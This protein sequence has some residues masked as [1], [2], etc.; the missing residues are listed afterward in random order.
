MYKLM[1]LE[2]SKLHKTLLMF[3]I[4]FASLGVCLTLIFT[5]GYSYQYNIEIWCEAYTLILFLF[6]VFCTVPVTW[7]L[8][9][10]KKNNYIFYSIVRSSSKRYLLSKLI[11]HCIY[12]FIITFFISMEILLISLYLVGPVKVLVN[13]LNVFQMDAFINHPLLYGLVLSL[14]RGLLSV[15][16]V[17]L[18]FVF[19]L[20]FNN[21]FII[22]VLPFAYYLLENVIL[23]MLGL[24]YFRI[25]TSLG[26]VSG[27]YTYGIQ[28]RYLFIGPIILAVCIFLCFMVGYKKRCFTI[29]S[30]AS[31]WK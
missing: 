30:T 22:M 7:L 20:L 21:L 27:G 2:F 6:P 19:S 24:P 11:A 23:S 15:L 1:K 17:I 14:W 3:S 16:F 8:F 29:T 9:Y 26:V 4:C 18:G 13:P 28:L 10:E 12:G 31:L 25:I 5:H